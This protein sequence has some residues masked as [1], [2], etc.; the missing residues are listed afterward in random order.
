MLITG[1]RGQLGGALSAVFP[2]ALALD[3][4]ALDLEDPKSIT[5]IVQDYAPELILN[6][7]AYTAVDKAEVETQ[8]ACRINGTALETIGELAREN[9]A[10]V[11]HWSTDYVFGGTHDNE[12]MPYRETDPTDPVNHYGASK[13]AGEHAL[14]SSGADY[15]IFRCS[16]VFSSAGQNFLKT[17]LKL[18]AS[19]SEVSVVA[20]QWGVPTSASWLASTIQALVKHYSI[21]ELKMFK[22][23][24][25]W[26]PSGETNWADYAR[27]VFACAGMN[28]KVLPI[29][30]DQ[31]PTPA[32]R[33]RNSRLDCRKALDLWSVSRPDWQGEVA[34]CVDRL[35]GSSDDC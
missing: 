35:M 8:A 10:L 26:T 20:D 2:E 27:Y 6:A 16:W 5:K 30:S 13:L 33:P 32:R 25:H 1:A 24:Y 31:W 22:G 29:S 18:G 7:A 28:V 23:I 21:D 9:N 12:G 11:V 19:R 4:E 3:R 14:A 15:L 17:M 34:S